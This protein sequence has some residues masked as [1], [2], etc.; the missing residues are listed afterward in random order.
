M[1]RC[2]Y[3]CLVIVILN[4]CQSPQV[5][6][7]T[8]EI[9]KLAYARKVIDVNVK[10]INHTNFYK[11]ILSNGILS[12]V[13]KAKL[14]FKVNE[15]IEKVFVKNGQWVKKGD[16]LVQLEQ[17]NQKVSLEKAKNNLLDKERNR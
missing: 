1:N 15:N 10:V 2:L 5:P 12:P 3:F 17:F 8:S 6:E 13:K 14:V 16:A 4:S 7:D 11:E 9:G